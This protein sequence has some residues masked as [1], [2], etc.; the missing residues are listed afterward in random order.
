MNVTSDSLKNLPGSMTILQDK[1]RNAKKIFGSSITSTYGSIGGSC[2][3][4]SIQIWLATINEHATS[5]SPWPTLPP[6]VNTNLGYTITLNYNKNF[7]VPLPGKNHTWTISGTDYANSVFILRCAQ[8]GQLWGY[9]LE[10][11][12]PKWGPTTAMLGNDQFDYYGQSSNI[13]DDKIL[14]ASQY[15]GTIK[16]F[17]AATGEFLWQYD[18]DSAP[19][20]YESAYGRNMPLS[21]GAVCDGMIYA[22]SNEHSPT[23]PLWRQSY[24][25]CINITD[26]TLIWKLPIFNMGMSIADG[27]LISASQ[28]DNMIY[29]IGKGPSAVTVSAPQTGVS[30]GSSFTITGTVTDQSPG[31]TAVAKKMGYANGVPCVSDASQEALMEYLYM[32]QSKPS[33]AIGVPVRIDVIDPNGNSVNIGTTKN[34]LDGVYGFTVDTNDLAAGPGLYEVIAS[35]DGS[36]SYGSSY[37]TSFFTV[38]SAPLATAVPTPIPAT[39]AETYF[40]PAIA[41]LFVLIVIVLVLLVLMMIKKRP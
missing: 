25:R 24:T 8:T 29:T 37:A 7:T 9:D 38:N 16:A 36:D 39:M 1:D 2:T 13:Y 14:C 30:M 18:A 32:Q 21:I 17:D 20:S 22:F 10:T 15:A 4:D 27:R 6:P 26:G 5:N 12:Q 23:N 31:A 28:Y 40:V 19:Y 3:G 34:N 11:G 35:F 41:G 33:N